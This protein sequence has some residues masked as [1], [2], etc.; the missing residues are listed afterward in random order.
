[1][2]TISEH[3]CF[4]GVQG[5]YRHASTTIGLPMRFSVYRPPQ[6]ASGPLP[7]LFYLA[8]LTCTEETFMIKAGAQRV[9]AEL[10][11]ILVACDTSPRDTGIAGEA[12]EWDFGS[13]AGFYLN[14]TEAPWSRHY[15]MFDYVTEELRSTVVE[16]FGA[17]PQRLGLS[18][19][20]MGGHGALVLALRKPELYR[21]VSAFAPISNPTRCPWGEKAFSRYLGAERE[22]WAQYDA[23]E[24]I[25]GH[26]RAVYPGILVD[27][28]LADQFL[29]Q[30]LAPD[31]LEAACRDAGQPLQLRRHAG[32]DHG[33]FFIQTFVEDHLRFHHRTLTQATTAAG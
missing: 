14:A 30:Q 8:G 3:G 24:L 21:S 1:M 32:Y 27:Q 13:G 29:D 26:G 31:A 7:T 4:G 15:R 12:D 5:Y 25:R 2:E 20:S 28:G 16:H 22:A 11:L 17:D 10:G 18:G 9:A 19:H 23:C 6:A 33:Y